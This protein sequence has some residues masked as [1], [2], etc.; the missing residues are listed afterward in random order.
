MGRKDVDFVLGM[1]LN[2][3]LNILTTHSKKLLLGCQIQRSERVRHQLKANYFDVCRGL[4][5]L[6]LNQLSLCV[7]LRF[8]AELCAIA[9]ARSSTKKTLSFKET[10]GKES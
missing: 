3:R 10:D 6:I 9:L 5:L 8:S 4:F 1:N 7:T 2:L